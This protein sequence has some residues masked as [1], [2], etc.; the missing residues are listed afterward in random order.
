M[1]L[2]IGFLKPDNI[3]TKIATIGFGAVIYLLSLFV[4]KA[5]VK[6]ELELFGS[7]FRK[8]QKT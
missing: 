4:T 8:N 7:L 3:I 1:G 6:E 5:Y 2:A